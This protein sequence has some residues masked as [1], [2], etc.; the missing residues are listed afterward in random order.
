[1]KLN[2]DLFENLFDEQRLV[3]RVNEYMRIDLAAKGARLHNV[4]SKNYEGDRW[5]VSTDTG[6]NEEMSYEKQQ[7]RRRKVITRNLNRIALMNRKFM[8]VVGVGG[9][10]PILVN[11]KEV[12]R[13]E[14]PKH[15]VVIDNEVL[16]DY[17]QEMYIRYINSMNDILNRE[18]DTIRED[19]VLSPVKQRMREEQ[20]K[21]RIAKATL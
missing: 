14:L 10:T 18:D 19:F 6:F 8:N 16:Q 21:L 17:N 15:K 11:Q 7:N 12:E 1:M 3:D 9:V 20:K 13:G 5:V 2:A 4:I